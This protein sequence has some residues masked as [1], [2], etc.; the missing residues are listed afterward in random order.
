M[1]GLHI[2]AFECE[3]LSKLRSRE[4]HNLIKGMWRLKPLAWLMQHENAIVK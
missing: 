4:L 1:T 3:E 2:E